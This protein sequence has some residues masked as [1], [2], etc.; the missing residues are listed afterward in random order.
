MDVS[1]LIIACHHQKLKSI[2]YHAALAIAGAVRGTSSEKLYQE[3]G[4]ESLQQRRWQRKFCTF[5]KVIKEKSVY[6][7]SILFLEV[8]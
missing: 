5:L 3:L 7:L 4:L 1:V 6:Y 2:R 8:I